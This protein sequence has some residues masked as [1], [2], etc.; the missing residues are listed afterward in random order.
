MLDIGAVINNPFHLSVANNMPHINDFECASRNIPSSN[1]ENIPTSRNILR[2]VVDNSTWNMSNDT[3]TKFPFGG[4][5]DQARLALFVS[6]VGALR[7]A[8]TCGFR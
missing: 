8:G 7:A 2:N 5:Q 3:S 6:P 1:S 4:F